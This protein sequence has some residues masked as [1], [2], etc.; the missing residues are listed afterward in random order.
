MIK[1]SAVATSI[2]AVSDGL[3]G[4]MHHDEGSPYNARRCREKR[5]RNEAAGSFLTPL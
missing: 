2:H 3:M 5:S 1:T 4:G